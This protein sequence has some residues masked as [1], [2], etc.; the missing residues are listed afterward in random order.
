MSVNSRAPS[1]LE[2]LQRGVSETPVADP[3]AQIAD[4]GFDRAD[5][6]LDVGDQVLGAVV[7]DHIDAV[8]ARGAALGPNLG[9]Q[10]VAPCLVSAASQAG[11][12]ALAGEAFGDITDDAGAE[13]QTDG[14]CH[15]GVPCLRGSG[16]DG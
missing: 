1:H 5:L 8:A 13:D 7:F 2:G 9:H 15:G 11:V 10:P 16:A 4:C 12:A 14:L 3:S 6:G